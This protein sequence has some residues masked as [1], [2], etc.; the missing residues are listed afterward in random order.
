MTEFFQIARLLGHEPDPAEPER[1]ICTYFTVPTLDEGKPII[2]RATPE[3]RKLRQQSF[4]NPPVAARAR[5]GQGLHDRGEALIFA[6]GELGPLDRLTLGNHLPA[7]MKAVTVIEKTVPAG[8]VWDLSVRG[9]QWDLDDLVELYVTVNVG[10]LRLLEGARVMVQGNVF[11]LTCQRVSAANA[12]IEI[13]P[14]PFSVDQ[15]KGSIHGE[16]GGSGGNGSRGENGLTLRLE[17]SLLGPRL[18]EEV[19]ADR[20]DG[21]PGT[22]GEPGSKGGDGRNGGMCKLAEITLRTVEG[23][24]TVFAQAGRGGDG[25]PGGNGGD[26]G[27]GGR[28]AH[29]ARTVA[30]IFSRGK[31]GDGGDGGAGGRGGHGGSGGIASNIYINVPEADES[32]IRCISLP[33]QPGEG[34][35][36]GAGGKGGEGGCGG[37]SPHPLPDG[38]RGR[39][40][41]PGRDGAPGNDGRSRPAPYIFVNE[42]FVVL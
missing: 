35:P 17:G 28:G 38:T 33:S 9:A 22:P 41:S 12:R 7:H 2:S 40:G 6:D 30:R 32:K 10:T 31:G 19:P 5:L 15:R 21:R 23:S 34:G 26:G 4:F 3:Q 18:R 25:G 37:Q 16:G 11:S 13:L 14:T 27:D 20:L 29:G 42:Q 8:E 39:S 24:L 36:S 1:E